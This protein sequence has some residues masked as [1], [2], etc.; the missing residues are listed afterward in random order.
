M[1]L[2]CRATSLHLHLFLSSQ[3]RYYASKHM[4][5]SLRITHNFRTISGLGRLPFKR[6]WLHGNGFLRL[7]PKRTLRY[8]NDLAIQPRTFPS[9]G[10]PL[11]PTDTKFEEERLLGYKAEDYYP[12]Q[13]G[14][15]FKSR[16][17]VLAKLG[18]GTASTVW[19]CR[20]LQLSTS[21]FS[22]GYILTI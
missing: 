21:T 20:D 12:V 9:T 10:F 8:I 15:V 7:Y 14:E 3:P 22:Q 6:C 5:S 4:A 17:Q 16:Y 18:Y 1:L 19:L 11:L 2:P 13:L